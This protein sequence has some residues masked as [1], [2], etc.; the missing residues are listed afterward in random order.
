MVPNSCLLLGVMSPFVGTA[1]YELENWKSHME[2]VSCSLMS[3]HLHLISDCETSSESF[4]I[5]EHWGHQPNLMAITLAAIMDT[6]LLILERLPRSPHS[7]L[8]APSIIPLHWQ[9]VSLWLSTGSKMW[10]R[11]HEIRSRRGLWIFAK[12]A[13]TRR[14]QISC[15]L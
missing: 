10:T 2:S 11:G 1:E 5:W 13:A 7:A 9:R 6:N 12:I 14:Y 4:Y 15:Q 8:S 3:K